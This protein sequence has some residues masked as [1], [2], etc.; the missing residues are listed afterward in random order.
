MYGE[1]TCQRDIIPTSIFQFFDQWFALL[2]C[3]QICIEINAC[4]TYDWSTWYVILEWRKCYSC[5]YLCWLSSDLSLVWANK[6]RSILWILDF[7]K[8]KK[9]M[10]RYLSSTHQIGVY[11]SLEM[12]MNVR[13]TLFISK[14]FHTSCCA[15]NFKLIFTW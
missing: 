2:F 13:F 14:V 3:V 11:A 1:S 5:R 15:V 10:L 8:L 6:S 4:R 7:G 12:W 9:K